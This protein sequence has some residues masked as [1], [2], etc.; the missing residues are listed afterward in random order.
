FQ[1]WQVWCSQ[2]GPGW[3]ARAL[4]TPSTSSRTNGRS[5]IR[6]P[7]RGSRPGRTTSRARPRS[8]RS[9]RRSP[10]ERQ[11][12]GTRT[13]QQARTGRRY[14]NSGRSSTRKTSG[15]FQGEL[16]PAGRVH[17]QGS[18]SGHLQEELG[19]L[20]D[21]VERRDRVLEHLVGAALLQPEQVA[22][23]GVRSPVLTQNAARPQDAGE[24]GQVD[25]DA[26]PLL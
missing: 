19:G 15:T 5:A 1:D 2:A 6:H 14:R 22:V 24:V 7:R 17:A 20:V 18:L 10:P 13:G 21:V 3:R 9:R 26:E 12:G 11:G 25:S 4:R 23:S 16:G 8:P